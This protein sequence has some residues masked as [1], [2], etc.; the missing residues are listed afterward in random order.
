MTAPAISPEVASTP[1]S[2]IRAVANA[3]WAVPGAVHLE[4]G[5]PDFP[6]PPHIVEAAHAAALAG[7]TRYGPS[8]GLPAM[9]EAVTAKLARDNDLDGVTPDRVVVSAGGVGALFS[10]YRTLLS[11]GDE[12]LVPDPG[13]TNFST[14]ATM[15]G[16]VPRGYRLDPATN[17]SPDYDHL[18][19]LRTDRTRAI[20]INSPSNPVGYQWTAA[21]L[22]TVGAWAGT[23]NLV[24]ISDEC[25][26]QL[27]LDEPAVTF[28]KAAP[29]TPFVSVFSLSKSYAMTGWR[30]GYALTTP[31][32]AA[33][34]T[35]VQEA[36]ASCVNTMTQ[37]AAIAALTGE[38]SCVADMRGAYR[39]RRDTA[40]ETAKALGLPA[41]RPAG[42][43]YL[44][45]ESD[46]SP[47]DL[48]HR[49]GTAVAPGS[50]FGAE[51]AGHVRL[52]L[53]AA[54]DDIVRGLRNLAT[55]PSPQ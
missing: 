23:H 22:A 43:F 3:A 47:L 15:L 10:T 52:S 13:W 27:W 29:G 36:T 9:R 40:L 28:S 34:I 30:V 37:H 20:V 12:I 16:A 26:D 11:N 41:T 46:V 25:Y 55:P 42:A 48:L 54:K 39:D 19:R 50:A 45:L 5:E 31:E 32:L 18:D 51:G 53:A 8:A 35:R 4:F 2:G 21:Q 24:V 33:G 14:L 17:H 1:A 49:T 44:W 6:T 38:Q 7:H